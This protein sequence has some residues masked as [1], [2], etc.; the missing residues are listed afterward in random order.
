MFIKSLFKVL[1]PKIQFKI[2]SSILGKL[3]ILV[4]SYQLSL[5]SNNYYSQNGED[6]IIQKYLQEKKGFY[7]DIGSGDPVRGSN[8][9]FLYKKGWSGILIDPLSRNVFSSKIIRRKDKIIRGLVGATDKSYPFYEMYPYEYS[10]TN[11]EIV[12]DLINNGKA[13]LVKKVQLNTFSVS[14]LNLNINLDQPSLLSVDCEGFDLE[15][16]K[17][18]DLKTIEFRIIC[19]EDFDYNPAYK[20][21]AINQYLNENGY[22]IVDRAGPSSIYVKSSWLQENLN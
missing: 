17:T 19:V 2:R 11:N 10:T 15:V 14:E 5:K 13:N 6:T 7:L 1:P 16:L 22:E 4:K 8:T 20:S 18:I 21:S 3:I 9:F 12:K